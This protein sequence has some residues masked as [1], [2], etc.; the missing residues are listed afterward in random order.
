MP[1]LCVL[2]FVKENYPTK[3]YITFESL[4]MYSYKISVSLLTCRSHLIT[5]HG[6]HFNVPV[7]DSRQVKSYISRKAFNGTIFMKQKQSFFQNSVKGGGYKQERMN[8]ILRIN[9]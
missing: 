2:Y 6:R 5:W 4:L 7:I 8:M 9:V 1:G 3:N